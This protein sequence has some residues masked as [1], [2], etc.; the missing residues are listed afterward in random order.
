MLTATA[1]YLAYSFQGSSR[2]IY[3][4]G[5]TTSGHYQIEVA[6]EVCHKTA[7]SD[8]TTLQTA[9][10]ECHG[11]P[12]EAAGDTHPET[13]FTDP[14]NADRVAKLD[15][16][17]CVTCH[18]EHRPELV[19]TMGLSLPTD[20]CYRCHETIG[21]ERPSHAGLGFDTCAEASCHN[22]HDNRA[23]YEDFLSRHLNDPEHLPFA[24]NPARTPQAGE[25]RLAA[26]DADAP[27]FVSNTQKACEEWAVSAHA[28]SGV[29]CT[30]C[31]SAPGVRW[32]A[33][34]RTERCASCHE[35]E[36]ES[37]GKGRHGMR[38]AAGL[39]PMRVADA[40][41]PMQAAAFDKSLSCVAC[42][43]AHRFD[44]RKAAVD[45]CLSCHADEHSLHYERS[46]HAILYREDPT[47]RSG[48]SCA[49][50]HLP[51]IVEGESVRVLHN[52]NDTLRP[53]D[54]MI[55]PICANC[56]GVGFSLAALADESL[57]ATNFASSPAGTVRGLEMIRERQA[58]R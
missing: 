19:S 47:G 17:F 14:R 44:T 48:A 15:A 8:R 21:Q 50:C 41:L 24:K 33:E 27:A 4:P 49:T 30:G 45:A 29:N 43:G 32:Q 5:P 18:R 23:L 26:R 7:F 38:E 37:Y 31:H 58:N 53:N 35:R 34:V 16:R 9:C 40:R 55:R 46:K 2:R 3:L 6:C 12:L 57:I 10:V 1:S 52:Q 25:R 28:T 22:F 56:H 39:G 36:H 11:E 51:R 54:K 13:K 20:Y 42:H